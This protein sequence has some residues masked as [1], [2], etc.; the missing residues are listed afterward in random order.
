LIFFFL[1]SSKERNKERAP[2]MIT[3]AFFS[4]RYTRA[5]ALPLHEKGY[6]F[7]PFA[8]G[9]LALGVHHLKIISFSLGSGLPSHLN[10]HI[11]NFFI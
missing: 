6:K 11:P 3:L 8:C 2:E 7:A 1:C 10:N 5:F 9:E 4:A